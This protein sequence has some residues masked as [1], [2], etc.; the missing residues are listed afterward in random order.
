MILARYSSAS[1][2]QISLTRLKCTLFGCLESRPSWP[3]NFLIQ[4]KFP[5]DELFF[6]MCKWKEIARGQ[7]WKLPRIALKQF[8][9]IVIEGEESLSRLFF[10]KQKSNY[11]FI[12]SISIFLKSAENL[13]ST[14]ELRVR[15]G[16]NLT[17]AENI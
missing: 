3:P 9:T 16:C 17:V 14:R 13:V 6:Q 10:Q 2:A 7:I 15:F 4:L 11:R 1:D 5:S 12:C 8:L